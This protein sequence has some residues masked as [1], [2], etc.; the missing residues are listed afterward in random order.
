MRMFEF[1]RY[2]LKQTVESVEF[3]FWCRYLKRPVHPRGRARDVEDAE[4]KSILIVQM[5]AI[6]DAVM[7]T[8]AL[9][10]LRQKFPHAEID[11]LAAPEAGQ[12]LEG[13]PDI[14]NVMRVSRKY[15]R[16]LITDRKAFRRS[17]V[18]LQDITGGRY[19]ACVDLV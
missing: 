14:N 13:M 15:W 8:P 6:G 1:I 4:L 12:M 10:A 19:D 16:E 7:T 5:G 9:R 11:I 2:L 18:S 3:L 17:R